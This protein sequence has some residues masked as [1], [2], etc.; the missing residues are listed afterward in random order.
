MRTAERIGELAWS[1][2]A[3]R[4]VALVDRLA[5]NRIGSD[6]GLPEPAHLEP[7]APL[8]ARAGGRDDARIDA[9][10][11]REGTGTDTPG[12]RHEALTAKRS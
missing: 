1:G 12:A 7:A 11:G 5:R 10:D 4:Y 2:E 8:F 9:P 3:E 6:R